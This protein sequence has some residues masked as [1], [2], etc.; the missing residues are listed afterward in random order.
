MFQLSEELFE[1][2]KE[3]FYSFNCE[4]LEMVHMKNPQ[5]PQKMKRLESKAWVIIIRVDSEDV[6]V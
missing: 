3:G 1:L 5:K 2:H 4:V 6:V